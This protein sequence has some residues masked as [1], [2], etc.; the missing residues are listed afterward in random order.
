MELYLVKKQTIELKEKLAVLISTINIEQLNLELKVLEKAS[1]ESGFWDNPETASLNLKKQTNLKNRIRQFEELAAQYEE[2]ELAIEFCE[3]GEYDEQALE[4]DFIKFDEQMKLAEVDVLLSAESDQLDCLIEIN[5]GAGGTESQD[6]A[7]MLFEMYKKYLQ[8]SA[9]KEQTLNYQAGETAGIKNAMIE[10]KGQNA[11][12]LLKGETGVHRLVRISPF[13][14][15][16]RRHTSFAA[17]RVSPIVSDDIVI[18]IKDADLRIDTFRSSGAGGQGVNTTDSAVR[19]THL[20]TNTVVT[21]QNERSQIKNKEVALKVLKSKLYELELNELNK[22]RQDKIND[23]TEIGW[24]NQ[25][26]SYV[27]H[28]YKMVKDH[29]SNF[30]SSQ[31]DKVLGGQLDDFLYHNLLKK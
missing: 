24:G 13:D 11:Y 4:N 29:L 12:G 18:E 20:P 6:W 16:N 23:E 5:P 25:K 30:E 27:L 10:V 21:C 17:V 14:T 28:P 15:A 7:Q 22:E 19:I 9:F 26:R 3:A 1:L 2:L 8:K 31:P